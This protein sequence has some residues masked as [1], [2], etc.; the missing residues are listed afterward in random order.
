MEKNVNPWTGKAKTSKSTGMFN[1]ILYKH[2][3]ELERSPDPNPHLDILP[4][5]HSQKNVK[6]IE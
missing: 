4:I 5:I 1:E 6:D 2:Y 3:P